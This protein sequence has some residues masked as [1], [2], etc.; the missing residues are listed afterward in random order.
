MEPKEP[1]LDPPLGLGNI[2]ISFVHP[3]GP[4][5]GAKCKTASKNITQT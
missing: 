2:V 4:V 3:I 1:P 5:G